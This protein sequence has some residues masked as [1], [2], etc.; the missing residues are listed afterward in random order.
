LDRIK[1]YEF[2]E[3][4]ADYDLE[5]AQSMLNTG[6]YL[7]VAFMCQ[8]AVEKLVKGLFVLN[9]EEEPP[10]V[11]NIY[12]IF[13]KINWNI[14]QKEFEENI[15]K[16]KPFMVRLVSYYIAGRYPSYKEM[17]SSVLHKNE[18]TDILSYTRE[19]YAWLKSLKA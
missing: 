11:H 16:Y 6:R 7:Y 14:K 18:A 13:K 3:D 17:L 12:F 2:W 1:K 9:S 15:N 4:I 10:K 5:T 19:V 8:Q